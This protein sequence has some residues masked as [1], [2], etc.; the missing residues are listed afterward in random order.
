MTQQLIAQ[1]SKAPAY[2]LITHDPYFSIWSSSDKLNEST[3][4]HWT[5]TDH[6]LLGYV[7][8]DGKLYKFL[9]AAPRKL[10]PILANSDLV[11][12][13]CRF[14]ET[15][16]ATNWYEPAFNDNNWL[17]GKGMFGSKNMDATT[18]WNSK[19]I[20]LRRTFTVTENN[21]NQLLLTLKYDDNIKVYL[22]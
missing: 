22:N 15:K 11:G 1:V 9:G 19:E 16:P 3:T 13:D 7:S 10:Q 17:T 14:T 5:G 21:F 18:E 12:F 4:T 20:W 6:S 2:P 8:V